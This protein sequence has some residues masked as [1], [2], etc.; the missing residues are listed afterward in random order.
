[1]R[2]R[3]AESADAP[4]VAAIYAPYVTASAVSFETEA[5]DEGEMRSRIDAVAGSY[6]WIVAE[7]DGALLGYAYAS[8]FRSRPAYRFAVET[9]VY[10]AHGAEGRGI[11]RRLYTL[12]LTTLEAQ[13]F[14]QAIAAITLPN[15][16]S[17]K[18]HRSLGFA[19]AGVYTQVGYKLGQWR[20]VAL[21]QRP[22][23]RALE[24]PEEPRPLSAVW[25]EPFAA[26]GYGQDN[27]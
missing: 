14:T 9:T 1:M 19:E 10:L 15:H 24:H 5:P 16:A 12:L 20:S 11:G 4:A 6:P 3:L 25:H 13:G 17:L 22:L 7:E 21:W 18:L 23:A 27:G 26:D 8:A 2:L